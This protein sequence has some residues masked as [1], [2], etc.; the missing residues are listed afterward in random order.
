MDI[1][2]QVYHHF[3]KAGTPSEYKTLLAQLKSLEKKIMSEFDDL[4]QMVTDMNTETANDLGALNT[5]M[6]A[7][8]SRV[9]AMITSLGGAP[10]AADIAAVTAQL[11]N[12]RTSL[13]SGLTAAVDS[14]N[15]ELPDTPPVA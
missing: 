1:I 9:E 15:Q 6:Q 3:V 14:L 2:V 5:A 10:T 11:G 8:F 4:K 13:H 12:M 7:E